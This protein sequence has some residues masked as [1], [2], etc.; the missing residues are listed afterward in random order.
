MPK[1]VDADQVLALDF[2]L[3]DHSVELEKADEIIKNLKDKFRNIQIKKTIDGQTHTLLFEEIIRVLDYVGRLSEA[4]FKVETQIEETYTLHYQ[5]SPAL[6]KKLCNDHYENLHYPYTI[7]KNRCFKLLED[8][9][10]EYRKVWK[11]N[12]PNWNI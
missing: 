12:P 6:G 2:E 1:S 9:D 5:K 7:L 4:V 8:L 11:K 3:P 10:E